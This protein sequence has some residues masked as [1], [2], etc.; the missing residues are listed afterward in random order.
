MPMKFL[1]CLRYRMPVMFGP[2]ISPRQGPD[3]IRYDFGGAQK[4]LVKAT[5]LTDAEPLESLLPPNFSLDGEPTVTV[6]IQF[7]RHLEWLAGR[8]YNTFGIKIPVRFSGK[9]DTAAGPLL[10]VLWENMAEPIITGR[11]EL[12]F[13]KLYCEIP[14]PRVLAGAVHYVA[15]W[16]GH[17]F[18]HLDLTDVEDSAAP[19][20]SARVDGVL[21]YRYIPKLGLPGH[22]DVE[23]AAL[24]PALGNTVTTSRYRSARASLKF[25]ESKWQQLPTMYTVVNTLAALPLKKCL[26][27]SIAECV[28]GT[29]LS[30]QRALY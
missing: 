4:T 12:G 24:T 27:A 15:R 21:H 16:D 9:Q 13:A 17:E 7:Y 18:A 22:A 25:F 11:E 20:A 8:G 26:S 14:E 2:S 23:H 28:G 30:E 10:V 29:D 19:A 6:E 1:P 3:G 5:F